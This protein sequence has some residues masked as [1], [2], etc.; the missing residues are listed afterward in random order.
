VSRGLAATLGLALAGNTGVAYLRSMAIVTCTHRLKWAVI[1]VS[2]CLAPQ[3]VSAAVE[4]A[5][6]VQA[7]QHI[8]D[9]GAPPPLK[10][11]TFLS[12]ASINDFAFGYAFGGLLGG[13][14]M[15]AAN[16]TT[17]WALYYAH[18]V[19]WDQVARGPA[20]AD[21]TS[22]TRTATFSVVNSMRIYG[23]GFILTGDH[24]LSSGFVLFNAAGD[25]VAYFVTDKW[26]RNRPQ[27]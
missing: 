22:Q 13:G 6:P 9:F 3:I 26:W 21:D 24:L 18:E 19:V 10:T 11:F 15:I 1:F 25:A 12:L 7:P 16:L 27:D 17:G 23:L 5:V 2:L 14:A 4:D 20:A 8:D